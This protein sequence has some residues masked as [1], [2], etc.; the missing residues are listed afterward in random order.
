MSKTILIREK[1]LDRL[2]T[3]IDILMWE[4]KAE[5]MELGRECYNCPTIGDRK[6][7]GVGICDCDSVISE[8]FT[9]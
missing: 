2:F 7:Y 9:Y 6:Q 5:R 3:A 1:Q 4:V 8:Q